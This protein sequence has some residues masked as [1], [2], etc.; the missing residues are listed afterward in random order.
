MQQI[1]HKSSCFGVPANIV[2]I[3]LSVLLAAINRRPYGEGF[4]M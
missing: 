2:K 3:L 4:V 1:N